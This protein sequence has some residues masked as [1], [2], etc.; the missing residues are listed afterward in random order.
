MKKY[1]LMIA[2]AIL[3]CGAMV[4]CKDKPEPEEK[5]NIEL[6]TP[7]N[8]A[9][10]DA[11]TGE[12]I[13]IS[14]KGAEG[15]S[16]L[17]ISDKADLSGAVE[18]AGVT[19]PY[20]L[21]AD[22][23]DEILAGFGAEEGATLKLYWGIRNGD[24]KSA[25]NCINA[26]R[27]AAPKTPVIELKTPEDNATIDLNAATEIT[28]SWE[29]AEGIDDYVLCFSTDENFGTCY[30][31][32][33]GD[34]GSQTYASVKAFNNLMGQVGVKAGETAKVYWTVITTV[35]MAVETQVRSFTVTRIATALMEPDNKSRVELN[36]DT[37]DAEVT[38][39]W[40]DVA[41]SY[42]LYIGMD[43]AMEQSMKVADAAAPSFSIS[44]A[45]I[46]A[47]FIDAET[48]IL[49]RYA[50]NTLYWNVKLPDGSW[51]AEKASMFT[52]NGMMVF[53][54]YRSAEEGEL[55][56]HVRHIK[57]DSYDA[58]WLAEDLKTMYSV[59][60]THFSEIKVEGTSSGYNQFADYG[61][62]WEGKPDWTGGDYRKTD[63]VIPQY[64]T[65]L[66]TVY[67]RSTADT[68]TYLNKDGWCVPTAAEITKLFTEAMAASERK[69]C[70]IRD[71]DRYAP[72]ENGTDTYDYQWDAPKE[73]WNT[74]GMNMGPNGIYYYGRMNFAY[75]HSDRD[76][77]N[78]TTAYEIF[79]TID[80]SND[81]DNAGKHFW[82]WNDDFQISYGWWDDAKSLCPVRMIYKGR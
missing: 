48:S 34:L 74:W 22:K 5:T 41:D 63:K 24:A 23:V 59:D 25:V 45:D 8:D 29:K 39:R 18:F 21:Q 65:D 60:G 40:A 2:A 57:T 32:A 12:A 31:E 19:S 70:V 16:T 7:Q 26:T 17:M 43:E 15:S 36:Y 61:L 71:Y 13:T 11:A 77:A 47:S 33:V 37:P 51:L 50:D 9:A 28:F 10:Y 42:E 46:Q 14:W 54:D 4:S 55:I 67:Y 80:V 1:Y 27:K 35:K 58:Y 75:F 6:L 62:A 81:P 38:F 69:A 76:H 20:Y 68:P 3:A 64:F 79:Y 44:H 66:K 82:F 30:E 72:D 56:Y 78:P 53:K 49:H 52:L 73:K